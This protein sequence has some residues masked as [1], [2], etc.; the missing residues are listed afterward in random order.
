MVS[1]GNTIDTFF[2]E[3][4]QSVQSIVDGSDEHLDM[5]LAV[6]RPLNQLSE[7]FQKV[8]EIIYEKIRNVSEEEIRTNLMPKLRNLNKSCLTLIGAI[9]TSF[10]YRDVR[11]ALKNYTRQYDFFKEMLYDIHHFRISR[12]D[13]FDNLLRDL[14]DL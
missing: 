4:E 1:I 5:I 12:D 7:R 8:N 2:E 9:R 6:T 13:D 3:N 10:L 11:T 14:N